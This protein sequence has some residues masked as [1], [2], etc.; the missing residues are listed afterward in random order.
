MHKNEG[1]FAISL[2]FELY[3]GVRD[4]RALDS[5]RENLNGARRAIPDILDAFARYEVHA[6]WATVGLL[7]LESRD[8]LQLT[9]PKTLPDYTDKSLNP[10]PYVAT[11]GNSEQD[12][13][14]HY[15][16]SLIKMIASYPGQ[17]IGTHTFSHYYCLEQGQSLQTF[18]AD[19][20]AALAAAK[21]LGI[22]LRSLVFPRNQ[23]NPD[24]LDVCR[25][26]G[27]TSYR[28]N[29]RAW[30]YKA[31][32]SAEQS[33]LRRLARLGDAY[34]NLSGQNCYLH[35]E[36]EGGIPIEIP[37]SRFLRPASKVLSAIEPLRLR[38]IKSE[39]SYAARHGLIYHLWW[40]PHN[41]GAN[42]DANMAFLSEILRHYQFLSH[43]FG[44]CSLNMGEIADQVLDITLTT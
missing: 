26:L 4:K 29:A 36:L 38:R 30:M 19:L 7:F 41:F 13:P 28:G 44:M 17:E 24:Y 18:R 20:V 11:I 42:T 2:D 25:E 1:V 14:C 37:A 32:N 5:Y 15:A 8:E 23:C 40:H 35:S 12:D 33:P 22:E 27:I 10:Y 39:M 16:P 21:S 6:T 3:W 34:F 31:A 43:E 9:K